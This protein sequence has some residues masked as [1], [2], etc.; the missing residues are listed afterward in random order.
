M[1][2]DNTGSLF[3]HS[4]SPN[5]SFSLDT[6]TESIRYITTREILPDEELCIHYGHNL[7]FDPVD[8]GTSSTTKSVREVELED[9][10]GGLSS[11]EDNDEAIEGEHWP[12]LDGDPDETIPE[13]QLPFFR[14]QTMPEEIKE[15]EPSAVR[16]GEHAFDS[17]IFTLYSLDCFQWTLGQS[18]FPIENKSVQ[19]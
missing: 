14:V 13:E 11:L 15:E 1:K 8:G 18:I 9:E 7:W 3:N 17:F 2:R 5:L 12:L 10:W 6:D 4:N 16:T 19:C